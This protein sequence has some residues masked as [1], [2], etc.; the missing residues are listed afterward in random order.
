MTSVRPPLCSPPGCVWHPAGNSGG[1]LGAASALR[2]GFISSEGNFLRLRKTSPATEITPVTRMIC[3][4][5]P[6]S[7][8]CVLP[9][10][11]PVC[12]EDAAA[13]VEVTEV[14]LHIQSRDCL[15]YG[16]WDMYVRM[17]I[18][19]Y[20][21]VC[22]F[23]SDKIYE[24]RSGAGVGEPRLKCETHSMHKPDHEFWLVSLY[25]PTIEQ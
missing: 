3:F 24:V 6:G 22:V 21:H 23:P 10:W 18:W 4:P 14:T 7:V 8:R 15:A 16:V 20:T 9:P 25:F 2:H 19:I 5:P 13:A 11:L 1:V 17:Y 12:L